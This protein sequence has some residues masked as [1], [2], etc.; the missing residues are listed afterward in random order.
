[1]HDT[2]HIYKHVCQGLTCT[3]VAWLPACRCQGSPGSAMRAGSRVTATRATDSGGGLDKQ[4]MVTCACTSCVPQSRRA[5]FSSSPKRGAW[6]C[7]RTCARHPARPCSATLASPM[8]VRTACPAEH[9]RRRQGPPQARQ[10]RRH[11]RSMRQLR[12]AP[13]LRRPNASRSRHGRR[14]SPPTGQAQAT[15]PMRLQRRQRL[16]MRCAS[17]RMLHR[18]DAAVL[19]LKLRRLYGRRPRL[20]RRRRAWRR[21]DSSCAP[22]WRAVHT[23]CAA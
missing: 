3:V 12:L 2:G 5:Q 10:R 22:K 19:R 11:L 15:S 6:D 23:L 16:R 9:G 17:Q 21:S 8:R 20:L 18:T 13:V 14:V 1:M 7:Q 4:A